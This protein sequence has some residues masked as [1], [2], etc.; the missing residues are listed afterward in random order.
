MKVIIILSSI[1][2]IGIYK[3]YNN[4]NVVVDEVIENNFNKQLKKRKVRTLFF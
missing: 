3:H 2:S 1:L 4:F